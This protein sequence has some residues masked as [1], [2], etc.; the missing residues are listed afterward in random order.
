MSTAHPYIRWSTSAQSDGD[1]LRRQEELTAR[2]HAKHPEYTLAP[3][4]IDAGMSAFHGKNA[5]SGRLAEF[6]QEI[7][8]GIVLPGDVLTAESW[9]RIS[10]DH[11]HDTEPFLR[12]IWD[13]GC[14]IVTMLDD[15]LYSAETMRR[16]PMLMFMRLFGQLQGNGES[17][18]KSV[19]GKAFWRHQREEAINGGR[20]PIGRKLPHWLDRDGDRMVVKL[21]CA[22]AI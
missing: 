3:A 11:P 14:G 8:E 1:S 17:A 21:E 9:S 16:D 15:M 19:Y 10:R 7:R 12:E 18:N 5:Q 6:L 13:A 20:K 4:R 2:W 22:A